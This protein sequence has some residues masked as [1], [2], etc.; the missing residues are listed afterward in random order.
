MEIIYCG[1]AHP[2][3]P[4]QRV[5]GLLGSKK[6]APTKGGGFFYKL[7]KNQFKIIFVENTRAWKQL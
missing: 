6:T 3:P 5:G 2:Q 4:I 7:H 1:I